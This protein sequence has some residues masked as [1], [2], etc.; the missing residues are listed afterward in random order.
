MAKAKQCDLCKSFYVENSSKNQ[1]AFDLFDTANLL[2]ISEKPKLPLVKII[3]QS[4]G[5]VEG[6]KDVCDKCGKKLIDFKKKE[7]IKE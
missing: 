7:L 1:D 5:T 4:S 6:K 3:L 2:W